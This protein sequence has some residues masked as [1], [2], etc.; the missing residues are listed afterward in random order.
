MVN[1]NNWICFLLSCIWGSVYNISVEIHYDLVRYV[2]CD[3]TG[4]DY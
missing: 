3:M 4:A 1:P 2:V